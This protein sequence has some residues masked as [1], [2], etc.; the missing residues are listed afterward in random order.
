MAA[1]GRL[2]PPPVHSCIDPVASILLVEDD[3]DVADMMALALEL[4]GHD[5]H[6]AYD[7][8]AGLRQAARMEPD[9]AVLDIG[10][11]RL[12]GVELAHAL[13]QMHGN[14]VTLIACTGIAEALPGA[15]VANAGFDH[16]FVKPVSID[17]LL[18]AVGEALPQRDRAASAGRSRPGSGQGPLGCMARRSAP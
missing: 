6:V 12:D 18:S 9:V 2:G 5:V 1:L 16:V 11:P 13:R 8:A 4:E 15:R 17:T 14:A 3:S 7:G 10:L